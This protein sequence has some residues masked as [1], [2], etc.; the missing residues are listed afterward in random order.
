SLLAPMLTPTM[1]PSF[2]RAARRASTAAAP[3]LLKPSRLI[4]PSSRLSRKTRGRGVPDCGKGVTVPT[5][6]KPKPSLSSPPGISANGSNLDEPKPG[7]EQRVGYLGM[8]VEARRHAHWIGKI[9]PE[10]AHGEPRVVRNRLGEW[11]EF[12]RL[13]GKP[14]G[15]LGVEHA[16]HRPRERLEQA[17]HG[18]S[19]GKTRR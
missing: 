11:G 17:D 14:M 12:Q 5:S 13:D 8:L 6:T 15:V 2:A 18:V 3:S 1:P 10:G 9:E 4:T 16:Q 7:L 19:S